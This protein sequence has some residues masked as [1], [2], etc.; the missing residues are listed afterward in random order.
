MCNLHAVKTMVSLKR[1]DVC[2]AFIEE[3]SDNNW[4]A[5]DLT[6]IE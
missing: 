4:D 3:T 1:D 6:N 5:S 2:K